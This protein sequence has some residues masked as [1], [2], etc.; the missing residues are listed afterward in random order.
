MNTIKRIYIDEH[1]NIYMEYY[2]YDVK[3]RIDFDDIFCKHEIMWYLVVPVREEFYKWAF[4]NENF[5][6]TMEEYKPLLSAQELNLL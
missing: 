4:T 6:K 1:A 5:L 3:D 2:L